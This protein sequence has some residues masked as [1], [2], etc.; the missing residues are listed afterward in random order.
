MPSSAV[1]A[2]PMSWSTIRL[3]WFRDLRDQIRDRRTVFMLVLL[4]LI[5]YPILGLLAM[6]L[7]LAGAKPKVVGIAGLEYLPRQTTEG[8]TPA[9]AATSA[10]TTPV[11]GAAAVP[12]AGGER[13]PAIGLLLKNLA[14][15]AALPPLVKRSSEGG[16]QFLP[17]Y[18]EPPAGPQRL[19][20][21]PLAT[22]VAQAALDH[23]KIDLLVVVP[24]NFTARLRAGGHPT[25]EVQERPRDENSQNAGR[26]FRSVLSSWRKR[27]N[28]VRLRQAGLPADFDEPFDVTDATADGLASQ[29]GGRSL[30]DMLVRLVPFMLV[31]WALTGALYPA[32]DVCAGEKERGTMETL[33]ISPASREEIVLGKFFTIWTLSAAATLWNMACMGAAAWGFGSML[34]Q[35][36][37]N[38]LAITWCVLS[39]L[40][41]TAFFSAV[42]LAMGA[43]A[44]S[45][46]EG[47]YYLMPLFL[48]TMPLIF[49]TLAPGV[50]L[51]AFYSLV[52]VTGVALLI[53]RLMTG[54]SLDR[55]PWLY[56][57]P[58]LA[59]VVLYS[60]LA[61][62]WAI[63]QFKREEVLF[64]EAERLDVGLWIRRLFREKEARTSVGQ[65]LFCF[66][67]MLG[68]RWL[69]FGTGSR[70]VGLVRSAVG[71]LTF[72]APP[73]FMALFLTKRPLRGLALRW[74]AEGFILQSV[75]L[76]L[77][78]VPALTGLEDSFR[79]FAPNVYGL[80]PTPAPVSAQDP[81][82]AWWLT[83]LALALLPAISEEMAFRGLILSGLRG[84]FAPLLATLLGSALYALYPMNAFWFVPAFVAGVVLSLLRLASG[85]VLPAIACHFICRVLVIGVNWPRRLGLGEDGRPWL[86]L[87]YLVALV[88]GSLLAARMVGQMVNRV[89]RLPE[90]RVEQP[91]EN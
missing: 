74:P 65:A 68:L 81:E 37:L 69:F 7:A 33:L 27:L 19:Q 72:L 6:Q 50:E 82:P 87:L 89:A 41:L 49:L 53:Q 14:E 35:A 55:V 78:V 73:L 29:A 25:L 84:R 59:A 54:A 91:E 11:A 13:L 75:L 60:L 67:L 43:Y 9:T 51:N 44:R 52:P 39:V 17:E 10:I 90:R 56:F 2:E 3:V 12:G 48:V 58:V 46:K 42:C 1:F 61:L 80:M 31:M 77:L 23:K 34:P 20:I 21:K 40:P 24:A 79:R 64:R 88:L 62:R 63:E 4:P 71:N 18:F 47:Q 5:L 30:Q 36:L 70:E 76:S 16:W 85:S 22:E 26:Q 57:I 38:P 45:S 66:A 32:V 8:R 15:A 86:P 28:E 83:L